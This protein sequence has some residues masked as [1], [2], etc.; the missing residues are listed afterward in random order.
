M[1]QLLERELISPPVEFQG[2]AGVL[3]SPSG[4]F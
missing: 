1:E 4:P 3:D 2:Q